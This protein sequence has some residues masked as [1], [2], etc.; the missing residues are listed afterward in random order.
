MS[1]EPVGLTDVEERVYR[2]LLAAGGA[3]L[4]ELSRE[5]PA[6]RARSALV[7]LERNGLVS[8]TPDRSPRFIAAPPDLALEALVLRRIA[9]LDAVRHEAARLA[10]MHVE[11]RSPSAASSVVEVVSG[12]DATLHWA[13]QLQRVATSVVR[14][15]D[16]PPH[17]LPGGPPNPAEMEL[18]AKGVAYRVLYHETSF[19][20]PGKLESARRCIEAGE[21][22]RVYSGPPIKLIIADE[23]LALTYSTNVEAVDDSLI[24]HPSFV[25]DQLVVLF[26]LL[27][28]QALPLSPSVD[29]SGGGA[30]DGVDREILVLLASGAKDERVA[31]HLGIGLRS[32]RRRVARL[33]E[34]L[35]A[36][37]RFQAGVLAAKSDLI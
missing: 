35:G 19:D 27:W 31:R 23:R 21:E 14:L 8:R 20:V 37:T 17:V 16:V 25:L 7:A 11:Q 12:Y 36:Q 24:V 34:M 30:V 2:S 32:V 26:D 6:A 5:V 18:L 33:M 10:E 1:L 4:A 9:D 3:T 29:A 13:L 15:I 28:S 22:A